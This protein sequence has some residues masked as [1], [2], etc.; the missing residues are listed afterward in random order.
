MED[1]AERARDDAARLERA[2]QLAKLAMENMRVLAI[3]SV[4]QRAGDGRAV[5]ASVV[6]VEVTPA[7][8]EKL[9]IL[10]TQGALQV[11]LRHHAVIRR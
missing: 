10:S 3:G 8:A 4:S 7:E 5:Y 11:I 6:T 2:G 1:L 9:A